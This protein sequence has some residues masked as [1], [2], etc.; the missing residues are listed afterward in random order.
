MLIEDLADLQYWSEEIS[1]A[2]SAFLS[3]MKSA[4]RLETRRF[5]FEKETGN[6]CS[7]DVENGPWECTGI[8]EESEAADN[9]QEINREIQRKHHELR[10][11]WRRLD[12]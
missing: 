3:L 10:R 9:V 2:P 6:I 7:V 5:E 12:D 8:L 4:W 1:Q 11:K